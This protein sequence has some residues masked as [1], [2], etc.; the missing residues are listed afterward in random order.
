MT[1]ACNVAMC[2]TLE[3]PQRWRAA[4]IFWAGGAVISLGATAALTRSRPGSGWRRAAFAA[5]LVI[6]LPITAFIGAVVSLATSAQGFATVMWPCT[7]LPLVALAISMIRSVTTRAQPAPQP[8]AEHSGLEPES[9]AD[10]RA[11]SAQQ[12]PA[13][14]GSTS[15]LSR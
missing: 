5:L 12:S 4:W 1:G 6:C 14:G 3:D 13:E 8:D 15:R 2:G 7:V 11:G 10:R 9:P